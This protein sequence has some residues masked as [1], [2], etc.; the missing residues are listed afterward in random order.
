MEEFERH[1]RSLLKL[2]PEITY[3][4]LYDREGLDGGH[5][6]PH[7]L[8]AKEDID[9]FVCAL[10][11]EFG[12]FDPHD[13]MLTSDQRETVIQAARHFAR[14][15]LLL[16]SRFFPE[17]N[18]SFEG[19]FTFF[20]MEEDACERTSLSLLFEQVST[21]LKLD[22]ECPSKRSIPSR[23]CRTTDGLRPYDQIKPDGTRGMTAQDE[24]A[25]EEWESYRRVRASIRARWPRLDVVRLMKRTVLPLCPDRAEA[26][27]KWGMAPMD[28]GSEA[29]ANLV[30]IMRLSRIYRQARKEDPMHYDLLET[31]TIEAMFKFVESAPTEDM[32]AMYLPKL[33]ALIKGESSAAAA[34][35]TKERMR[36]HGVS[37]A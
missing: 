8:D 32:C 6:F 1:Y 37:N 24:P 20:S 27:E 26:E 19:L 18:A 11:S 28:S 15:G 21:G 23:L 17:R 9:A 2:L 25:L 10:E 4:D 34:A 35:S 22:P 31:L 14:S 30:P 36:H 5:P 33:S 29:S 3:S 12:P 13:E 16:L 7:K